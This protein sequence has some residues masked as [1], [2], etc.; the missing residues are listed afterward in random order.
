MAVLLQHIVAAMAVG[1]TEV[2]MAILPEANLPGGRIPIL[3]V[4]P[5]FCQGLASFYQDFL[6][7]TPISV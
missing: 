7:E 5:T 4:S 1:G 3:N 6:T 2:A